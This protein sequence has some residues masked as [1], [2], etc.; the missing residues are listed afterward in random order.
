MP[1][2]PDLLLKDVNK[3]RYCAKKPLFILFTIQ[4]SL[5]MTANRNADKYA[6]KFLYGRLLEQKGTD[7]FRESEV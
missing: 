4:K 6:F 7:W 3:Q 2:N 5:S 1:L